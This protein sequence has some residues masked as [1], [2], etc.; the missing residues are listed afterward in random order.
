MYRNALGEI[1]ST[2][3]TS[4]PIAGEKLKTTIDAEFQEYFHNR[5]T[6]GLL[7][8]GRTS[9]V[10]IAINPKNGEVLALTSYPSFDANDI[11][12]YLSNPN[13]PLFNRAVS[14]L[15]SPGS[16][17]KPVHAAAALSEGTVSPDDQVYS[18]G[19]IEIPNPYNPDQPSRF[20]DWRAHG[21]VNV[22]SAIARSSNVYFY[23]IGGGFENTRGLGIAKLRQYWE[24]FGLNKLT[25][26]DLPGEAKGILPDPEE[27]EERTGSIWRIGDTYN[28]SIGQGDLRITPMELI[29]SMSA[30]ANHGKAF[31][32]HIAK[33]DEPELFLDLEA[34]E[35]ALSIVR[36]GMNDAVS[37]SYGTAYLLADLPRSTA[38]KTGSA[39]T[40]NNAKTNA[41]FVGYGPSEDPEIA[42]LILVEDAKEGS[43]NAVPIAKDVLGWYYE[44]RLN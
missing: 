13:Q 29:T 20:V 26:I 9:G 8:L 6:Q 39:Q 40:A 32:P 38:A 2:E 14:G 15:Y 21:W 19:Y 17:I 33:T 23:A 10:G 34:L 42:I 37:K 16:T 41:L 44:N 25:G 43:L 30:I 18:A 1:K 4:E 35:P 7:S 28:V 24:K 27:K 5:M 12:P 22:R 31:V 3:R 36:D 11:S